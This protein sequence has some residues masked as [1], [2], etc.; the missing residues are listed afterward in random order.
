MESGQKRKCYKD[1]YING[2]NKRECLLCERQFV[3]KQDVLKHASR[4]HKDNVCTY[5]TLFCLC[6]LLHALRGIMNWVQVIKLFVM[7]NSTFHVQLKMD[8]T[9]HNKINENICN[10]LFHK[11]ELI[12]SKSRLSQVFVLQLVYI[13]EIIFEY[14]VW[15]ERIKV[16]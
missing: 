16:L 1:L 7:L 15:V 10:F 14:E 8:W 13:L 3:N 2:I 5:W 4:D 11:S 12:H 6:I 9:A